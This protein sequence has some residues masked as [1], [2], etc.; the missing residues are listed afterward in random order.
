MKPNFDSVRDR[1][2][3]DVR[4]LCEGL[5]YDVLRTAS[6]ELCLPITNENGDEA[7]LVIKFTIPKGSR[8]G[9]A[10][11]GYAMAE[12]FQMK[13]TEKAEKAKVAAEKKAAKIAK[14]KT[15]REEKAE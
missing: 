10:Y 11:D 8:D 15:R 12:A 13:Q 1:L 3:S 4:V 9:D 2:M 5:Q 14:D 7:Y 6:Q